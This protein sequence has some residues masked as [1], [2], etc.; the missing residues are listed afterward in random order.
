[1][2][3][4][5]I[6]ALALTKVGIGTL[7]LSGPNTYTGA[8]TVSVG[9]LQAGSTTALSATSDFTVNAILDLNGYSNAIGSLA[10]SG[11]ITNNR[12]VAAILTAGGDNASTTFSGICKTAPEPSVFLRVAPEP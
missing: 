9:T 3:Q 2:L 10:G 4:N 11:T 7:T 1:M 8:T 5:G 12:A 6:G